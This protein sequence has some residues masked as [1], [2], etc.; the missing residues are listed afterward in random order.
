MSSCSDIRGWAQDWEITFEMK[1]RDEIEHG[2][3]RYVKD[4]DD[5]NWEQTYKNS[6]CI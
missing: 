4:L 6:I 2:A 3:E 5:S 1:E